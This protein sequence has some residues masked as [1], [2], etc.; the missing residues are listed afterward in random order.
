MSAPPGRRSG[1]A[2]HLEPAHDDVAAVSH[3]AYAP[4][5]TQRRTRSATF[6]LINRSCVEFRGHNVR[7]RYVELFRRPPVY[8]TRTRSWVT[9]PAR[10]RDLVAHLENLNYDISITGATAEIKSR[11]EDKVVSTSS[12]TPTS[13]SSKRDHLVDDHLVEQPDPGRGLW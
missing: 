10:M 13:R 5:P 7:E 8:N 9:T 12:T 3:P 4:G 2:F 11:V 6:V 1:P